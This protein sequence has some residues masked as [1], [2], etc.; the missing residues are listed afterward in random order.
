MYVCVHVSVGV[1]PCYVHK[2]DKSTWRDTT[3]KRE[4]G[5]IRGQSIIHRG[6]ARW[7]SVH[8][9]VC[10]CMCV[11]VWIGGEVIVCRCV[12]EWVGESM[13]AARLLTYTCTCT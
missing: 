8:V 4:G 6:K 5:G 3:K 2:K 1:C 10:V 13:R 9:F 12:C 11:C 7:E